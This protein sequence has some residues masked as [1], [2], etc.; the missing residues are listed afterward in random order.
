MRDHRHDGDHKGEWHLTP[1]ESWS[2]GALVHVVMRGSP[3][4]VASVGHEWDRVGK[5]LDDRADSLETA[6][7]ALSSS[8]RGVAF[9]QYRTMVVDIVAASRLLARTSQELR[10]LIYAN[11]EVLAKAQSLIAALPPD[12]DE[13]TTTSLSGDWGVVRVHA[14]G[15]P[16]TVDVSS[17]GA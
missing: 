5:T 9:D 16:V 1:Y 11:S 10:D 8:W 7:T 3:S 6:L 14:T 17:G 15:G 12:D 13:T 2:H 4:K